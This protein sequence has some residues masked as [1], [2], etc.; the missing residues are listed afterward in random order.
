MK[1]YVLFLLIS[2]WI[3]P[4]STLAS[5]L[6]AVPK[7]EIV[8]IAFEAAN[9]YKNPFVELYAE[10]E[11][12]RPDGSVWSIPLFWDGGQTWKLRISP[13]IEGEWSYKISSTDNGLK[14]KSGKFNCTKSTSRGS[15]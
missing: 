15:L 3:F 2:N 12:Y 8:E 13:D 1:K 11:L 6:P 10:A 7:Y 14:G 5:K 4:I 9:Q